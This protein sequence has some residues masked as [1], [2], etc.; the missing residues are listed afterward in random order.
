MKDLLTYEFTFDRVGR[1]HD[2]PPWRVTVTDVHSATGQDEGAAEFLAE[3]L[4]LFV[5]GRLPGV[6]RRV[7][8]QDVDATIDLETMTATVYAGMAH[9]AA[10]ATLE[11]VSS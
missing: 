1:D 5:M 8:S 7:R 9:T 4:W 6:P 11:V 3:Q 2:V 10:K